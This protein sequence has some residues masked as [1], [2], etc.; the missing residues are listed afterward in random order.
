MELKVWVEGIQRIVCGVTEKTTC[1][2]KLI[3]FNHGANSVWGIFSDW[4]FLMLYFF[5]H[6]HVHRILGFVSVGFCVLGE[7]VVGWWPHHGPTPHFRPSADASSPT[8][9]MGPGHLT[10]GYTTTLQAIH[11]HCRLYTNTAGYTTTLQATPQHFRLHTTTLQASPQDCRLYTNTAGYTPTLQ[12][13][14]Q[15]CL[16]HTNTKLSLQPTTARYTTT[17][18]AK[19]QHCMLNPNAALGL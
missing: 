14:P 7:R 19:P 17:L 9:T 5:K 15:H 8:L 13:S 3:H 11:Q 10:A 4:C 6:V 16:L 2:V 12:A 18:H 1:Q